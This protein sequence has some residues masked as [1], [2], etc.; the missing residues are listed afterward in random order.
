MFYDRALHFFFRGLLTWAVQGFFR[1][2]R[3]DSK[4]YGGKTYHVMCNALFL[5]VAYATSKN[6]E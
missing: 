4:S 6:V 1:D 3:H 5:I 2:E